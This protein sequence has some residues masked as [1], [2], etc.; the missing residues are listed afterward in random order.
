M[1]S[2]RIFPVDYETPAD[3]EADMRSLVKRMERTGKLR[4]VAPAKMMH[5]RNLY[6]TKLRSKRK[7]AKAVGVTLDVLE[8]WIHQ[9]AW[10]D[11]RQK[12][13]Y[14]LYQKVS[15]IRRKAIPDID[16]KHDQLFHNLE[17]LIEDTIYRIKRDEIAIS[18]RD[19][20]AL[21]TA[22]RICMDSRRTVHK[23]EG[24]VSR[25]VHEL[26]DHSVFH[27]FASM[28]TDTVTSPKL[29][30]I[31][32]DAAEVVKQIPYRVAEDAELED[33]KDVT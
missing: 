19:L 7:V 17:S 22:A 16:Q 20:P 32:V 30:R 31:D 1:S 10:D 12:R 28:L 4:T 23:K 11:L 29:N 2:L 8:R 25:H 33:E 18:P 24:P 14:Q 13:E 5:A 26:S 21:A 3:R 27:E 15:G 9:F 6:V